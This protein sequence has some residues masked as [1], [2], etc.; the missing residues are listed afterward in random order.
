MCLFRQLDLCFTVETL[1]LFRYGIKLNR[2]L[3]KSLCGLHRCTQNTGPR[4]A[5]QVSRESAPPMSYIL[6]KPNIQISSC[7]FLIVLWM[8][9]LLL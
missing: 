5:L 4:P 8:N 1:F 6:E 9:R 7:R 3:L 2:S